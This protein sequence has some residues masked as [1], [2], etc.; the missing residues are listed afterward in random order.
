MGVLAG[1]FERMAATANKEH[2]VRCWLWLVALRGGHTVQMTFSPDASL[3][4]VRT[5]AR[6][7]YGPSL[8]RVVP[9]P[10]ADRLLT[11]G[12]AGRV[13]MS[14]DA[15]GVPFAAMQPERW[16]N[17]VAWLLGCSPEHLVS[18][19]R[20]TTRD[21]AECSEV[22]PHLAAELIRASGWTPPEP[23]CD[24]PL[25]VL[26]SG[27]ADGPMPDWV[28][29]HDEYLAHLRTCHTCIAHRL[30]SPVH[31]N[32]GA[33]IRARYEALHEQFQPTKS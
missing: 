19:G 3:E 12:E 18:S 1:L 21:A 15:S 2:N 11:R 16:I 23:G 29:A 25:A 4:H 33:V 20:V 13:L 31:C 6:E 28:A 7:R 22:A 9:V 17:R 30:R 10:C 26:E 5:L 24:A 8:D 32:V 14:L 27:P